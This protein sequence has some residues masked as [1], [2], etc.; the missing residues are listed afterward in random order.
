MK[1]SKYFLPTVRTTSENTFLKS[2]EYSIRAGLVKQS[3][4][5]IYSWLP[6]GYRVLNKIT[7]VIDIEMEKIGCS[8]LLMPCIQQ[9]SLW[10]ET[11]RYNDY[12]EE[13][14]CFKDRHN[15]E[16]LFGPTHE[17]VATD[18]VRSSLQSY[19]EL[20][21]SFYQIQ[22]KFRDEIRPRFG[23]LRTREF[24]MKDGYSF[25]QDFESAER[26]YNK[27]YAAYLHIFKNLNLE[28]VVAQADSGPIGGSL[29][30][31]FHII[32]KSGAED[33]IFFDEKLIQETEKFLSIKADEN[34]YDSDDLQHMIRSLRNNKSYTNDLCQTIQKSNANLDIKNNIINKKGIEV[35]HI[36]HFGTKYSSVMN[37]S[38]L[39]RNNRLEHCLMGSYGIGVSRLVGAI[40]E[41]NH[42]ER[43]IIWTNAT[44]PFKTMVINLNKATA[45]LAYKIYSI[46][47]TNNSQQNSDV[48]YDDTDKSIGTKL[49]LADLIGIPTQIIIGKTAITD[50]KLEI[51][52]RRTNQKTYVD[53]DEWLAQFI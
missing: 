19:K 34:F 10:K 48:L 26:T 4:S 15:N 20:P 27:M 1:L 29:T 36:F 21:I 25:D 51:K 31:E 42:D 28:V 38:F 47:N 6:L 11:G 52:D 8:K 14:L 12:G 9:A 39:N 17:E 40:I 2:H 7:Q 16:I 30:H 46:L 49:T 37:A 24:L 18:I 41:S 35:G 13:M 45:E 22:W 44:S 23:L 5:G 50:N 3:V 32:S 43:G 33:S 53:I